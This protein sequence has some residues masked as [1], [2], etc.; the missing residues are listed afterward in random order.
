MPEIPAIQLKPGCIVQSKS[1]S[2]MRVTKVS[3]TENRVIVLFDGDREI[4]FKHHDQVRIQDAAK[5]IM[6]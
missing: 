5:T 2:T 6:V 4:D 3:E 1:G